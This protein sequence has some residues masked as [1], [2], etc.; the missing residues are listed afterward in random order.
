MD[1]FLE[2]RIC[3]NTKIDNLKRPISIKEIK[4]IINNLPKQTLTEVNGNFYQT[5][6]EEIIPII[7]NLI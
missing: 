6:N 4:P 1:Q 2:K 7:Y 3:Q 5:C